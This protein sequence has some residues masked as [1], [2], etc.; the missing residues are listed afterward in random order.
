MSKQANLL[1]A[2]D[3]FEKND[4]PKLFRTLFCKG[5]RLCIYKGLYKISF[6]KERT[7]LEMSLYYAGLI[8]NEILVANLKQ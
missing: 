7:I 6:K 1:R 5:I 2:I 8:Q 3:H 4:E